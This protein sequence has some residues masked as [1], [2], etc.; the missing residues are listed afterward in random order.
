MKA[1]FTITLEH[2]PKYH[3]LAN[4]AKS[5][6]DEVLSDGWIRATFKETVKMSSYLV[7]YVVS[8]F[9]AKFTTTANGV[10]VRIPSHVLYFLATVNNALSKTCSI[11]TLIHVTLYFVEY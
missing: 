3:A 5:G 10:K 4:S 8:D 9:K 7:C 6:D 2:E 1:T 11:D